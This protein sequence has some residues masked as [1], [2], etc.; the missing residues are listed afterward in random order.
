M[1]CNGLIVETK[2]LTRHGVSEKRIREFGFEYA[3]AL[4]VITK[5]TRRRELAP[6]IIRDTRRYA[7]RQEQWWKNNSEICW[8]RKN[9]DAVRLT[10][11]F[12][13]TN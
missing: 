10:R 3:A 9:E 12:I 1:V 4:D 13:T 6:R 11:N 8:I 7:R 5:K 2:K